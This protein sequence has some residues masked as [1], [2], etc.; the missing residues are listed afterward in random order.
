MG[1]KERKIR[2]KEERRIAI[3]DAARTLLFREGIA[4]TSV[5]Q[6][7]KLTELSVGT[8]YL[9]FSSKE[10]IFA[11]LQEEGL[12]ILYAKV[13]EAGKNGDRAAERLARMAQA[14]LD[15]SREH[16]KYFDIFNYFISSPDVIFPP[17]LKNRIDRHGNMILVMVED[18]I[19]QGIAD[20]DFAE[21][22]VKNSALYFWG[23]LHGLIQLRK[24]KNTMYRHENFE[25]LY[26]YAADHF[27][28]GLAPFPVAPKG[29]TSKKTVAVRP[30]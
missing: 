1:I 12:D 9:Y 2:E 14:Y 28:R 8:I 5:H 7:A 10:E 29:T 30:H 21:V 22:N 18:A 25:E 3:L 24:L 15:F 13:E 26:R 4:S 17:N 23:S 19:K 20:G 6:I 16:K 27:I 11:T